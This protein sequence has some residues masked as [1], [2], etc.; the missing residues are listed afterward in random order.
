MFRQ[1]GAESGVDILV[2]GT[3]FPAFLQ[4]PQKESF[5]DPLTDTDGACDPES[6]SAAFSAGRNCAG[7]ISCGTSAEHSD[8]RLWSGQGG[9]LTIQ[10]EDYPDHFPHDRWIVDSTLE[11]FR[12]RTR[13]W[14][15]S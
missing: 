6:G 8:V 9:R 11:I 5:A 13:T 10:M 14:P 3:S 2:T 15:T 7:G 12:D 4:A 1:P